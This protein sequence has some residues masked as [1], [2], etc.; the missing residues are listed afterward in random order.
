MLQWHPTL[1]VGL[2]LSLLRFENL[3]LASNGNLPRVATASFYFGGVTL[4]DSVSQL[5]IFLCAPRAL[6]VGVK[7][8][9]H[10]G[11]RWI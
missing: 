9:H 3:V 5:L 8:G 4:E 2:V 11:T 6:G 1:Q 10:C 7:H